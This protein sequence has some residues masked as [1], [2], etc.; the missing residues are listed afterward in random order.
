MKLLLLLLTGLKFGKL[1]TT[2]G[3]M[4]LSVVTYAWVF[5]WWYAVGF[6]GLLFVHEMGHYVAARQRGLAVGAPT[7]IPFLG[8]WITMKDM[9]ADVETEAHVAIAGPFLGAL[10]AFAVYFWALQTDSRLLLAIS[11][12]GFFLNLFNLLPVSPLDGGRITAIISPR[13]WLLGAPLMVALLFYRPS[14]AL[15][16]VALLAA[17]QVWRAWTYDPYAEENRAYYAVPDKVRVEFGL[18]YLGL[19]AVLAIMTYQVHE[20]LSLGRPF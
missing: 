1:F 12:S 19:T 3:T 7:F 8:A 15:F 5:G 17:P 6:V 16:I 10:A 4:L 2:G 18:I 14:P 13:I 20:M 9:P 11:Y